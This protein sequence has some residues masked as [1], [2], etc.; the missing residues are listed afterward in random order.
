MTFGPLLLVLTLPLLSPLQAGG[1]S[2]LQTDLEDV[3]TA[4]ASGNFD[5]FGIASDLSGDTLVVGAAGDD[6]AGPSTG[7]AYVYRRSGSSWNPEQLLSASDAAPDTH[8]G[9]SV[10]IDG[11][12]LAVGRFFDS[13]QVTRSGAVYIYER[14]AGVWSETAKLKA[15]DPTELA[16]FG[17]ALD[18]EGDTLLIGARRDPE[19]GEAAGAA[20]VF[21]RNAGVWS[22]SAKLVAADAE[23]GATFGASVDLDLAS[24]R[25]L[26][27]AGTD[28]EAAVNAGA[29]YVFS[30]AGATWNQVA[31]LI[32]AGAKTNHLAGQSVA[33][34]GDAA[35]VGVTNDDVYVL[36]SGVVGSTRGSAAVFTRSG[37][38]WTETQRLRAD[39]LDS[40]TGSPSSFSS[41]MDVDGDVLVVSKPSGQF[42]PDSQGTYVYRR[43][44]TQWAQVAKLTFPTGLLIDFSVAVSGDSVATALYDPDLL[45]S[46]SDGAASVHRL[47]EDGPWFATGPGSLGGSGVLSE[48]SGSGPLT[49]GS[50]NA[51]HLDAALPGATAYMILGLS[52]WKLPFKGGVLLPAPDL[53][54]PPLTVDGTGSVNLPFTWPAA[55]PAGLPIFIQ[56]W[57]ADPGAVYSFASSNGLMGESH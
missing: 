45:P 24:G 8:F 23:A 46:Q 21:E 10:A 7:A 44:G 20:Y 9:R 18:L 54:L 41:R 16:W 6:Q 11:D 26:I 50:G 13:D 27:G 53:F 4:W 3:V 40:F 22:Q 28:N 32:V 56:A 34:S 2:A 43:S 39:D 49:A 52:Q 48:L 19:F 38:N 1:A 12:T 36:Q 51:L 57:V 25:L 15:A 31:K 17:E 14:S 42:A 37:A 30:G 55:V 33:L 29:A 5:S 35:V 47:T